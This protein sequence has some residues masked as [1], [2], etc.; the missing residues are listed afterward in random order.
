MVKIRKNERKVYLKTNLK[1]PFK[2]NIKFT[3]FDILSKEQLE[4]VKKFI[5]NMGDFE[6]T[7]KDLNVTYSEANFILE[8]IIETLGYKNYSTSS[9]GK[10][11]MNSV[12]FN[13][14]SKIFW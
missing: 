10:E 13:L 5:K 9:I 4:F 14:Y 1:Q 11:F 3:K 12:A 2:R 6:K 8:K 7:Q